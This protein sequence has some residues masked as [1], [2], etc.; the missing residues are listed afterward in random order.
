MKDWMIMVAVFGGIAVL[1]TV[2]VLADRARRKKIA[3][4]LAALGFEQHTKPDDLEKDSAFALL[5]PSWAD[6]RTA[7]KGVKW[8]ARGEVDGR[9]VVLVEHQYTTGSGKSRQTHVHVVAATPAPPAWPD[10]RLTREG[11]FDKLGA[12]FGSKDF[13]VEDENFNK[14]WKVKTTNEDFALL[15]LTPQVQAWSM[16][17]DQST[18]IRI[19][20]GAITVARRGALAADSVVG[21]IRRCAELAN[22]LPV[23]L[24]AWETA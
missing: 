2:V 8:T 11:L 10:V 22:L 6:L 13:T 17:L 12:V 3:E 18:M 23:E 16:N 5:G 7:G 24:E 4:A 20:P 14:R 19:G 15:V 1:V 9:P 21:L